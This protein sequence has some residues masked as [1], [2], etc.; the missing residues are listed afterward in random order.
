MT[1]FLLLAWICAV[2][3][4]RAKSLADEGALGKPRGG[5]QHNDEMGV[6]VLFHG[7]FFFSFFFPFLSFLVLGSFAPTPRFSAGLRGVAFN[8]RVSP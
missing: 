3:E 1:L 2:P 6:V 5:M 4:A 7:F 8:G